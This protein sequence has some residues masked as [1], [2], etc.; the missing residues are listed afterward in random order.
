MEK[1]NPIKRN[2]I[3]AAAPEFALPTLEALVQAPDFRL[4]ALITNPD[5]PAGRG[6]ALT[7]TA[8]KKWAQLHGVPVV[9]AERIP[10]EVEEGK[11]L[12]RDFLPTFALVVVASAL[13]IPKWLRDEN[14]AVALWGA[15]NLHPSLLPRWRGAAPIPWTIIAGDGKTGVTTMKL[16]K[17]LDAGPI[18]LQRELAVPGRATAGDLAATLATAG[19]ELVLETLRGLAARAIYPRPQDDHL[20]TYAPKITA[21]LQTIDW[22][23]DARRIDRL[24]RALNPAPL[25]RTFFSGQPVQIINA[26]PETVE[27]EPGKIKA[28]DAE[29]VVVGCGAGALRLKEVKPA[30]KRAMPAYAFALGRRLAVGDRLG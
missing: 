18:Y 2:V 14:P 25:A 6:L 1:A 3:V 8:A 28:I 19:A 11:Q 20:A 5:R 10:A 15:V 16:T 26:E 12:L 13:F 22:N 23:Q 7:P 29:G 21:E 17:E 9:T 24:I 30:G 27:G 4:T